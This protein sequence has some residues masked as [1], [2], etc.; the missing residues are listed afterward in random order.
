MSIPN[1]SNSIADADNVRSDTS[2]ESSET[3]WVDS[4]REYTYD[5]QALKD[6]LLNLHGLDWDENL[7]TLE[8]TIP[9][10]ACALIPP[11][12]IQV[13]VAGEGAMGAVWFCLP[14]SFVL[15]AKHAKERMSP[16]SI[17]KIKSNLV[18][19]KTS[20][21]TYET[22]PA[23]REV[24]ALQEVARYVEAA[25]DETVPRFALLQAH[26]SAQRGDESLMPPRPEYW[27]AMRAAYPALPWDKVL[28]EYSAGL[29]DDILQILILHVFS[30]SMKSISFLHE[31]GI[32]HGD[33][34]AG[35]VLLELTD[36]LPVAC[37]ID[38]GL[39]G[40]KSDEHRWAPAVE[41]DY[42]DLR[43]SIEFGCG[44]RTQ[45]WLPCNDQ[46][47][48]WSEFMDSI[49]SA[50]ED[51]VAVLRSL[52]PRAR[53]FLES[54]SPQK[55]AD[56]ARSLRSISEQKENELLAHFRRLGLLPNPL[57]DF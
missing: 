56:V 10:N 1:S 36:E 5:L 40:S 54:I 55:K 28:V 26:S 39:S 46:V 13:F 29:D 44:R 12:Y 35:N 4:S 41:K 34:H 20:E 17:A 31:R 21:G 8:A 37:L 16:F 49:N 22:Y 25:D 57:D 15:A 7:Q 24:T 33:V 48:N 52:L 3:C 19:V 45:S 23:L 43:S 38:F 27:L 47:P 2:F 18:A 30:E 11:F 50:D 53:T 14:K 9:P 42:Y 32:F 51:D 6:D